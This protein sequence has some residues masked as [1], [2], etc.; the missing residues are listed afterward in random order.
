MKENKQ[1]LICTIIISL[2]IIIGCVWIGNTIS[3]VNKDTNVNQ[4]SL[5]INKALMTDKETAEYLNMSQEKFNKLIDYEEPQKKGVYD[6]YS[7]IPFVKVDG[8][9][10][11]NKEQVDKWVE[12]HITKNVDI[13]TYTK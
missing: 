1:H 2:S 5:A 8:I 10:Y 6:T 4:P 3:K 12:Y 13:N 7:F 9:K 11:F